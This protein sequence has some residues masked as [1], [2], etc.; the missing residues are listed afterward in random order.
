MISCIPPPRS[1]LNRGTT[2]GME[3]AAVPEAV[4]EASESD[5]AE[6]KIKSGLSF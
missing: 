5:A 4:E 3:E 6:E 1:F 2:E